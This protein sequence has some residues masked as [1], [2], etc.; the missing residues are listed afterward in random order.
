MIIWSRWGILLLP[1]VG[2]GIG[3]GAA[4]GA[5][6]DAVTGADLAPNLFIGVGLV[7]SGLLVWLFDR[8][9]LPHLDAPR[10]QVVLQRL[11]QPVVQPNGVRQTHV[12]VPVVNPATGQQVWVRPRS[13][14]FFVPV[15]IWPFVVAGI[16]LVLTIASA[17]RLLVG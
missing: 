17:V 10:P 4:V 12:Q 5:V 13:S 6:I 15:G 16:G 7:L 8:F 14:L 3:V 11:P 9:A 1:I 2:L